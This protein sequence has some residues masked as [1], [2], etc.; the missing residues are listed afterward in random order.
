MTDA[1]SC[2]ERPVSLS[3]WSINIVAGR[4][5]ERLPR[6]ESQRSG[7]ETVSFFLLQQWA[8]NF[9]RRIWRLVEIGGRSPLSALLD[10][11]S[12][13]LMFRS[14]RSS[15]VKQPSSCFCSANKGMQN[16]VTCATV[17]FLWKCAV[18]VKR[19]TK[20][21]HNLSAT[22]EKINQNNNNNNKIAEPAFFG[23][24]YFQ[25]NLL[26]MKN[27]GKRV[28]CEKGNRIV[29]ESS[30]FVRATPGQKVI[31]KQFRFRFCSAF[32]RFIVND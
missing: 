32:L 1:R 21:R 12:L 2:L 30:G 18:A 20:K 5:L 4:S 22:A 10:I 23:K 29:S 3:S 31:K 13:K 15:L 11:W 14:A 26:W 8:I 7:W 19:G 9:S 6:F 27:T 28:I 24:W 25:K 16:K 17:S